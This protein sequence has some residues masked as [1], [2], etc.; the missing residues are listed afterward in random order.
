MLLKG[1]M[2][3]LKTYYY[4]INITWLKYMI[5]VYINIVDESPFLNAC[6]NGQI[7]F[8]DWLVYHGTSSQA[9]TQAI[10]I[11]VHS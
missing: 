1:H 11:F 8:L 3:R 5:Y 4:E 9:M 7:H 2:I 10:S 6:C